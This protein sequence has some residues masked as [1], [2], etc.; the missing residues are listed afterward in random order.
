MLLTIVV[1]SEYVGLRGKK[2]SQ[3]GASA[4]VQMCGVMH[5]QNIDI[6]AVLLHATG[7]HHAVCI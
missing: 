5:A 4:C 6:A 2:V 7:Y 1:V 3:P